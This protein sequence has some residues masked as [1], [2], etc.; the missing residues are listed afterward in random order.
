LSDKKCEPN[1]EAEITR[2]KD[3]LLRKQAK[4]ENFKKR[5]KEHKYRSQLLATAILPALDT[6]ERAMAVEVENTEVKYSLV[7]FE[8][9]YKSFIEVLASEG[10]EVI[11][12]I[13]HPSPSSD[14]QESEVI[15]P[16]MILE[17]MEKGY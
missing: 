6:F 1:L 9:I 4:L 12:T 7:G 13:G 11:Q 3:Q 17:E 8:M 10:I 5:M 2:L 15:A 14:E 16:G